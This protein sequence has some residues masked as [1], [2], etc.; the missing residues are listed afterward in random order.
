MNHTHE[1]TNTS[2]IPASGTG[3]A[4]LGAALVQGRAEFRAWV[5]ENLAEGFIRVANYEKRVQQTKDMTL[6]LH[7]TFGG[8]EVYFFNDEGFMGTVLID[9][10][11]MEAWRC[12]DM[13]DATEV[14]A[15][16]DECG[17]QPR[18]LATA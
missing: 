9:P 16:A 5:K 12:P 18:H 7:G 4:F 6:L 1:T 2:K 15:W 17:L 10:A 13:V 11:T 14:R 3:M 8:V